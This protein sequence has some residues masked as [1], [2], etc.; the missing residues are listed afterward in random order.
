M[1]SELVAEYL[2]K[3]RYTVSNKEIL[4]HSNLVQKLS[5]VIGRSLIGS[6]FIYF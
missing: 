1:N 4:P 5:R 6:A 2:R 3:W